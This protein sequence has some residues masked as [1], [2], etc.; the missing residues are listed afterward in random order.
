MLLCQTEPHCRS[1][2][3]CET[4]APAPSCAGCGNTLQSCRR[5]LRTT[6][7]Q[8]S[9]QTPT[10]APQVRTLGEHSKGC[11]WLDWQQGCAH[12]PQ[13]VVQDAAAN[14]CQAAIQL[15]AFARH[16]SRSIL[17]CSLV[18]AAPQ[19]Y[20]ESGHMVVRAIVVIRYPE[21]LM[22]GVS[23]V[24]SSAPY[25]RWQHRSSSGHGRWANLS[26]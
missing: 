11:S 19:S 23:A 17:Q 20:T 26:G 1:Q 14:T 21:A 3:N 18:P 2:P 9:G 13:G 4:S 24:D 15:D 22:S 10:N 25:L 16:V 12:R 8:P 6:W 7:L 5:R